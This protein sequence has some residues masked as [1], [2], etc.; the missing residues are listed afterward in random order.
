MKAVSHQIPF[1]KS[2]ARLR[3]ISLLSSPKTVLALCKALLN[4]TTHVTAVSLPSSSCRGPPPLTPATALTPWFSGRLVSLFIHP[5]VSP[6]PTPAWHSFIFMLKVSSCQNR[7]PLLK[8]IPLLLGVIFHS[9]ISSC[10]L[11]LQNLG[12]CNVGQC[13]FDCIDL[14]PKHRLNAK[15]QGAAPKASAPSC[16]FLATSP[17][18]HPRQGAGIDSLTLLSAVLPNLGKCAI[19][20]VTIKPN[21]GA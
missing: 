8:H 13:N 2:Y 9:S 20:V 5:S 14:M 3:L 17:S 15:E 12:H 4:P 21:Q 7:G 16:P 6:I 18:S 10:Y 19:C 1:L 11:C